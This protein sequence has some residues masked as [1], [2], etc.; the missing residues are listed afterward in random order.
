MSQ[1]IEQHRWKHRVILLFAG[2][3]QNKT[4]QKQLKL[5][6]ENTSGMNDRE[7]VVYRIFEEQGKKPGNKELTA[8]E[9]R[10]L[11]DRYEAPAQGFTFL[12]IG[13]DGTVKL[14]ENELVAIERLF[15]L[16]DSMPMRKAEMRR[17][18]DGG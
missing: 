11:R 13:K 8:G 17:K 15:G 10:Q 16:I 7:L 14:R 5:F 9:V 12:L 18:E 1:L 4:L 3:A 6:G 2:D